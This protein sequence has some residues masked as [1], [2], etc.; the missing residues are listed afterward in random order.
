MRIALTWKSDRGTGRSEGA[1]PRQR[2]PER[3]EAQERLA[4]ETGLESAGSVAAG[5]RREGPH[6]AARVAPE[7]R[8]QR[9][10]AVRAHLDRA[11]AKSCACVEQRIRGIARAGEPLTKLRR[12]RLRGVRIDV[13]KVD[14]GKHDEMKHNG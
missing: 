1:S 14:H 10:R 7:L 3:E 6:Q 11:R 5:R 2:H 9:R 4:R 13:P 8:A 12:G